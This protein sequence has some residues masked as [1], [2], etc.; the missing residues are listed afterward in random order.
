MRKFVSS[1]VFMLLLTPAATS[2]AQRQM[3]NLGRGVAVLNP[4]DGKIFI[5]W[6]MLGTDP[7][8]IAFNVYRVTGKGEP[9]KLNDTPLTS[10]TSYQDAGADLNQDNL[11]FVRPVVNGVEGERS[12][13]FLNKIPAYAMP[14]NYWDVRLNLPPQTNPNDC[15]VGDLD[16]DGEYEI[17]LKGEQRPRDTASTGLTGETVLQAYKLDGTLLWTINM[18]RNIREGAHDTQFMVA[19]LDG[20]GRAEVAVRTADGTEDGKGKVIGDINADW[21]DQQ[22]GSRSLGRIMSGP[23][24]LSIF[25]GRTGAE[26]ARANYIPTRDPIGGW[27]GIG[28]NGGNDNNGN[29]ANRFLACVAYLDGKLPSVVFCR[30]YYGRSVLAAWDYRDGKLASRWVFDTNDNK[31]GKDGKPYKDYAGMGA[32][33][34]S[35]ADVDGDGKDEIVYHSMVVDD[36]GVGLFTTGL[37]HGDA[38]HVS[39]LDP[40]HPGL[41]VY[42][43]HENEGNTKELKTPGIALYD[44]KTGTILWSAGPSED[45]GRGLAAD[46]DPRFPG[47]ELWANGEGIFETAFFTAKGEPIPNVRKPGSCNFAIWWDGDPLRE[48]LDRNQISK[49]DYMNGNLVNLLTAEGCR[50]N[51]GSKA[52]PALSADLFGDWREEV[53]FPTDDARFLR[54]FMSTYPTEMRLPTLMHDPQY[55]EAIAFQNV[56]YNQ[57][58]WPS[59]FIGHDM[60]PPTRTPITVGPRN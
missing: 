13:D 38:L 22:Q 23:E 35:V 4:G 25:D 60:K 20:D 7:D 43:I 26:L 57:P 48:I 32:H 39:D 53:I 11:Y 42:G 21:R 46:I 17:V 14:K 12:A 15:S 29:R 34:V 49:W 2:L 3:E 10:V 40:S 36:D 9:S 1:I 47:C 8:N 28:G 30:G 41:E 6:R 55:R 52:T 50:S 45:V 51:N 18:G 58:P 27:G 44:A 31:T 37:R 5:G 56:A 16:G 54:I 19:D 59:F 33:A 24:Y